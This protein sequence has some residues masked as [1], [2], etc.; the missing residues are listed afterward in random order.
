ME[1]KAGST[2]K[3]FMKVFVLSFSLLFSLNAF[4]VGDLIICGSHN[5]LEGYNELHKLIKNNS[6]SALVYSLAITSLCIG[7]EA[8]GMSHLQKASDSGHIAATKLLGVYYERNKTFNS[9][10]RTQGIENLNNAIHYYKKAAQVIESTSNYPK[11]ATE[12]MEYIESMGYL[13]YNVFTG[14]PSLYLNGYFL[15]LDDITSGNSTSYTDTLDVLSNIRATAIM[16]VERPS[17]SVWK[18]KRN[19]IYQAQQIECEALL[20]F[21][22]AVYP[23]EQ[24]R[25][26]IAQNCRVSSNECAEHQEIVAQIDQRI[27]NMFSQVSAA[28]QVH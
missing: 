20:R 9:S 4:S 14:L 8:E 25:I 26:Q 23:L 24:Q 19:I 7:K 15:A 28:P 1:K 6:G 27:D 13:S 16:C 10:E 18:S 2:I 11:G 21:A 12:D 3:S 22:E 5:N 17:L